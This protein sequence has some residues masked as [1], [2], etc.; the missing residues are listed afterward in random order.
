[1]CKRENLKNNKKRVFNIMHGIVCKTVALSLAMQIFGFASSLNAGNLNLNSI[2][3]N[4]MSGINEV[5]AAEVS[6]LNSNFESAED[7]GIEQIKGVSAD[8]NDK[9]T[10]CNIL[11][12]NEYPAMAIEDLAK[13]LKATATENTITIEGKT[14]KF[15]PNSR[16]AQ[17]ADGHIMLECP[18]KKWTDG[19][20]YI[21]V[22]FVVPYLNYNL[23]YN[24]FT[25]ELKTSNEKKYKEYTQKNINVSDYYSDSDNNSDSG[26]ILRALNA[27]MVQACKDV[28]T[29]KRI[30]LS[31]EKDK[32]YNI[33]ERMDNWAF[34]FI[35]DCRNLVIEGNNA[36]LMFEKPTNSFLEIENSE[37]IKVK[38]LNV[39]YKELNFTQG[40]ILSVDKDNAT[41][42]LKIDEGYPLP[43]ADEW[44]KF[45]NTDQRSGGWWFG[46]L[47]DSTENRMKYTE[48][49]EIFVD[50]VKE[51]EEDRVYDITIGSKSIEN[52]NCVEVGD[53]FVI[54]TRQSAYSI[55]DDYQSKKSGGSTCITITECKDIELNGVYVYSTPHM[56][57]AIGFAEGK[58]TFKNSGFKTKDGRLLCANSDGVHSWLGRGAVVLEGCTFMN[59]LDDHFNAYSQGGF[60]KEVVDRKSDSTVSNSSYKVFTIASAMNARQ[61]DEVQVYDPTN[62]KMLG[63]A[64]VAE[65]SGNPEGSQTITLDREFKD[66]KAMDDG[67][68]QPTMIYD[69]DSASRGSVAR[70][71]N[72]IYSRRYAWLARPV[73]SIFEGNTINGCGAGIG[74]MNEL[75]S[76]V[77]SEGGVPAAVT[78]R[79]NEIFG[80]GNTNGAYPINIRQAVT[81]HDSA[82]TIDGMLIENNN[83][84]VPNRWGSI[85]I[86][87]VSDL[88]MYN[89]TVTNRGAAFWTY[90]V[91]ISNSYV[92]EIDGLTVTH[93]NDQ[94]D[95]V[96]KNDSKTVL[97]HIFE[98]NYTIYDSSKI[99][100]ITSNPSPAK[101]EYVTKNS[102]RLDSV[103]VNAKTETENGQVKKSFNVS[104]NAANTLDTKKTAVML[105]TVYEGDKLISIVKEDIDFIPMG[106]PFGKTYTLPDNMVNADNVKVF[107]WEDMKKMVP[108]ADTK[109]DSF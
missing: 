8:F 47:M 48:T 66:I 72:F 46:Q 38:N 85:N 15:T 14:L 30:V 84:T 51:T 100:N 104:L 106:Q 6:T 17:D 97:R 63:R 88:Y 28:N 105:A 87:S 94:I 74:I 1:M 3:Q 16:L 61:G 78:L 101:S 31:F 58:T 9:V 82:P 64:F 18:A 12:I 54:N 80:D 71:C 55:G 98:M 45:F 22:S 11:H 59:N 99:K 29:S 89:N 7:F 13:I 60:V 73:N 4:L 75:T 35:E 69:I 32:T 109:T 93:N 102:F 5:S 52:V 53:R 68:A 41:F 79:N 23:S 96:D 40:K 90:P 2:S 56:F 20:L 76:A 81:K 62:G 103:T 42:K 25:K 92:K 77:K 107:V 86:D 21:P 10:V 39:D 19:R 43:A 57:A 49:A 95:V 44:V 108:L 91:R 67:F 65:V 70:N 27:A 37:N 50:S 83:I 36:T 34:L 33:S 26:A 24:R